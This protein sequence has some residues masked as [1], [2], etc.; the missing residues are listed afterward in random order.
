MNTL[1]DCDREYSEPVLSPALSELYEGDLRFPT[2]PVDRPYVIGNF[3]STLDGVVSYRLKATP[4]VRL[5]AVPMMGTV[6]SWACFG[7]V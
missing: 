2:N 3:V 4:A 7:R 5:S 6:L 1:V